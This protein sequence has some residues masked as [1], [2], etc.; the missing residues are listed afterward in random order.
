MNQIVQ[1]W[2]CGR[3]AYN[4]HAN[5]SFLN[6]TAFMALRFKELRKMARQ[7]QLGFA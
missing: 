4:W 6:G 1:P 7:L 5:A 2:L 3:H